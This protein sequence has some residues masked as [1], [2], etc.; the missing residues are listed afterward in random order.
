MPRCRPRGRYSRRSRGRS[1]GRGREGGAFTAPERRTALRVSPADRGDGG[2]GYPPPRA[3]QQW[4]VRDR[5]EV[6]PPRRGRLARVRAVR[7]LEQRRQVDAVEHRPDERPHHV[8]QV[9]AGGD[10]ELEVIAV[11][12]PFRRLDGADEDVV[13]R[14]GR[15]E[16]TEIVLAG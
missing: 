6:E 15:C 11:P 13:L 10:L 4:L 8:T 16:C 2:R 12:D 7:T 3:R 1:V 5:D 9:A 14:L